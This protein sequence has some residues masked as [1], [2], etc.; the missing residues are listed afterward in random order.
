MSYYRFSPREVK[1]LELY[2]GGAFM[3]DAARAAG[4]RGASDQALCN[5]GRRILIKFEATPKTLFHHAGSREKKIAQLIA[6]M[7]ENS[8]SELQQLTALV[9]LSK[10]VGG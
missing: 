5:T 6:H 10:C 2:W 9:I 4:Y 1:F 7:A 3:K 8:K